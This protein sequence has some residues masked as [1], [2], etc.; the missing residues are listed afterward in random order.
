MKVVVLSG[1]ESAGK[2][3]LCQALAEEFGAVIVSEYV[4]EFI[5]QQAR[6]TCYDDISYIAQQQLAYE[7]AARAQKPALLLLDT[8]LLSNKLW[9]EWLFNACPDWIETSLLAQYYD[10]IGLLAPNGVPWQADG[11]RCQPNYTERLR[12]YQAL[13][14]WLAQHKQPYQMITGSWQERYQTLKNIIEQLLRN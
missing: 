5:E 13:E 6:T 3:S 2:S 11:Q 4:R 10:F 9:S 14:L 12:F 7:Q 8:H 1:P